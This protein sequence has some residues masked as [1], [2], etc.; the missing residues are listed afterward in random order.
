M[1]FNSPILIVTSSD[2]NLSS[3]SFFNCSAFLSR[4]VCSAAAA[5]AVA[6]AAA[7]ASAF[8]STIVFSVE[9]CSCCKAAAAV[10][11]AA[12]AVAAAASAFSSTIVF[13]VETCSCCKAAAAEA[14]AAAL[15]SASAS[16]NKGTSWGIPAA[17]VDGK[18]G[19][20]A[21]SMDVSSCSFPRFPV[22]VAGSGSR[23]C[24]SRI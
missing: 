13:L 24:S 14:A 16:A 17:S 23:I 15:A 7:A 19:A 12:A 1:L 9:T 8:S 22:T 2:I 18:R 3:S 11:A 10:A 5:A 6:A 4:A 20:G 21:G